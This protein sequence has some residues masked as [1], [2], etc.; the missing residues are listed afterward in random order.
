MTNVNHLVQNF[1]VHQ[2]KPTQSEDALNKVAPVKVGTVKELKQTFDHAVTE[3]A[4]TA[5]AKKPPVDSKRALPKPLAPNADL[6]PRNPNL[7]TKPFDPSSL[8]PPLNSNAWQPTALQQSS[9][10][11]PSS[12]IQFPEPPVSPRPEPPRRTP[13]VVNN[14]NNTHG[15][16][17]S[18]KQQQQAM[19]ANQQRIPP[20]Q[21]LPP[22]PQ[23][24]LN[25][26]SDAEPTTASST[27]TT[28]GP[29]PTQ[30]VLGNLNHNYRPNDVP[31]EPKPNEQ[32]VGDNLTSSSQQANHHHVLQQPFP[33]IY[34]IPSTPLTIRDDALHP[35]GATQQQQSTS[36]PREESSPQ[37]AGGLFAAIGNSLADLFGTRERKIS[38]G[39]PIEGSFKH[40]IHVDFDAN[41]GY[42]G[43]PQEWEAELLS[44]GIQPEAVQANPGAII[45]ALKVSHLSDRER[46]KIRQ[47]ERI[48]EIQEIERLGVLLQQAEQTTQQQQQ[49]QHANNSHVPISSAINPANSNNSS[50]PLLPLTSSTCDFVLQNKSFE[51][52]TLY[53]FLEKEPLR[54]QFQV[55]HQI[56][57]G[58]SGIVHLAKDVRKVDGNNSKKDAFV[59]IKE[60]KLTDRKSEEMMKTELY[61][62]LT[63]HHPNIVRFVGACLGTP[64]WYGCCLFNLFVVRLCLFVCQSVVLFCFVASPMRILSHALACGW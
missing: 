62:M 4:S 46:A 41:R 52:T 63:I 2:N 35:N 37:P 34:H 19:N 54:P 5:Q 56:G 20:S 10:H 33:Q 31:T 28:T 50:N 6:S 14:N 15:E 51:Q 21:P 23:H 53:D 61:M 47:S 25:P 48:K 22:T 18:N 9:N 40:V 16:T 43:L 3:N 13:I 7:P 39:A 49:Q 59:A 57:C 24:A 32:P 60:I 45:G 44:S 8:P 42:V 17:N 36:V 29:K 1:E 30:L 58:A 64:K 26:A 12:P 38:I 11:S 27:T 55:M